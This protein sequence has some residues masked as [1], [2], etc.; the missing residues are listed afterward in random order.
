M[1]YHFEHHVVPTIPYRGLK[2]LHRQLDETGLFAR[3]REV[4][5]DGYVLLSG[6]GGGE[7]PASSKAASMPV[8]DLMAGQPHHSWPGL[9][10][11]ATWRASSALTTGRSAAW[12]TPDQLGVGGDAPAPA[13]RPVGHHGRPPPR[14]AGP[15]PWARS[16]P[17]AT[18]AS[19]ASSS[20]PEAS[21]ADVEHVPDGRL[22]AP[23]VDRGR[24]VAG[25]APSGSRPSSAVKRSPSSCRVTLRRSV[26]ATRC[27]LAVDLA[28]APG[29]RVVGG[30][31][32]P[33]LVADQ[34]VLAGA[35]RRAGRPAGPW[36]P[37]RRRRRRWPRR[38][39][40]RR[41]ARRLAASTACTVPRGRRCSAK[42]TS[43]ESGQHRSTW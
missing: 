13:G 1:E 19:S 30:H 14:G 8:G 9:V 36:P 3:H 43:T 22:E 39:T 25:R 15:R 17:A 34:R 12:V 20:R 29:D 21:M 23:Q 40:G 10:P 31:R 33:Q 6:S 11:Q 27:P 42:A 4:I 35:G 38:T 18:A 16:P 32:G 26:R 5:S 37:R 41:P 28:D 2:K 7:S 24:Q